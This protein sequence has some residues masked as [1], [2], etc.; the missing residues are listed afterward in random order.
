MEHKILCEKQARLHLELQLVVF[1]VARPTFAPT[2]YRVCYG[3]LLRGLLSKR[4]VSLWA[5]DVNC[6]ALN[7]RIRR[8]RPP[9]AST[10]PCKLAVFLA[11]QAL[12]G[13]RSAHKGRAPPGVATTPPRAGLASLEGANVSATE[14]AKSVLDAQGPEAMAAWVRNKKRVMVTDTTMRDAHQ[15]R[16][17]LGCN[18]CCRVCRCR[19][20]A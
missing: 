20:T 7:T 19:R 8:S 13:E 17:G 4:P 18:G 11:E 5:H 6:S 2:L 16:Y 15:V 9:R 10:T 1:Y 3:F 12:H 14:T